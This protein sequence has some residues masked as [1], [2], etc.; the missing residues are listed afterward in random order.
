MNPGEHFCINAP[1]VVSQAFEDEVVVLNLDKGHY[2]SLT[3]AGAAIWNLTLD[4]VGT[5]Q[6]V[7]ALAE[8]FDATPAQI[9][10]GMGQLLAYLAEEQLLRPVAPPDVE[11]TPPPA[12]ADGPSHTR[13]PFEGLDVQKF[14]DMEEMLLL[15]PIHDVNETGWPNV[16]RA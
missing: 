8:R 5:R 15:D 12:A 7:L 11:R 6:M 14:T 4:G 2:Y 3:R 9:E 16:K 1:A 10:A 13:P